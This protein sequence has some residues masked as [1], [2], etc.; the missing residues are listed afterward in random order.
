VLPFFYGCVPSVL[1]SD[2]TPTYHG[3]RLVCNIC[4]V[5]PIY[6]VG[7]DLQSSGFVEASPLTLSSFHTMWH[8]PQLL[9]RTVLNRQFDGKLSCLLLPITALSYGVFGDA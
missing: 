9:L 5:R 6:V 8:E 4:L 2:Q 7:A 3:Y 1:M